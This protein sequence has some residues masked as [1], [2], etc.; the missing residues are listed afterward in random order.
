MKS[1]LFQF[2]VYFQWLLQYHYFWFLLKELLSFFIKIYE[3]FH[4]LWVAMKV[5]RTMYSSIPNMKRNW[6][7]SF[8]YSFFRSHIYTG[9]HFD[10]FWTYFPDWQSL[11]WNF[12]SI[13]MNLNCEVLITNFTFCFLFTLKSSGVIE[14]CID[15]IKINV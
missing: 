15:S 11:I 12:I 7:F 10:I 4:H 9:N 6:F 14:L 2:T 8:N 13:N 1:H 5:L 3:L